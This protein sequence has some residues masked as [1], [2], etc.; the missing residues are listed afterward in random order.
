MEDRWIVFFCLFAN[1]LCI[2][3]L[4]SYL[5][6]HTGQ[7]SY[8]DTARRSV[9]FLAKKPRFV[10]TSKLEVVTKRLARADSLLRVCG[11]GVWRLP[12][13]AGSRGQGRLGVVRQALT[14]YL[15]LIV[16]LVLS[17]TSTRSQAPGTTQAS[18]ISGQDPY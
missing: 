13:F 15:S 2:T 10:T 17:S 9:S 8:L 3:Y 4:V 12:S 5:V 6:L 16:S 11:G 1:F 14:V 7:V 18:D